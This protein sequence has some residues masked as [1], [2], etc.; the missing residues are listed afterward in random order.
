MKQTI[1]LLTLLTLFYVREYNSAQENIL[2]PQRL[3]VISPENAA[4]LEL[5]LPLEGGLPI[6]ELALVQD[7]VNYRLVVALNSGSVELWYIN[8]PAIQA[9]LGEHNGTVISIASSHDLV[10]TGGRDGVINLWNLQQGDESRQLVGN[11]T[12]VWGLAFSPSNSDVLAVAEQAGTVS[13]WDIQTGEIV[14]SVTSFI[15]FID[16]AFAPDGELMAIGDTAGVRFYEFDGFSEIRD[17][18]IID[19]PVGDA[20]F[21]YTGKLLIVRGDDGSVTV[22]DLVNETSTTVASY[23]PIHIAVS[24]VEDLLFIGYEGKTQAWDLETMQTVVELPLNSDEPTSLTISTD[25]KL[26][27]IGYTSGAIELWGIPSDG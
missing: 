7:A 2:E 22:W 17:M 1:M 26:L 12:T 27:A 20:D 21:N 8:N 23:V 19:T 3:E 15:P 6:A 10:A 13:L 16:V 24:P 25:G 4:N 18:V 5:L 14:N 11:F 9:Q